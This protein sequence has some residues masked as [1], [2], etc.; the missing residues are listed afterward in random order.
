[1]T[2]RTPRALDL[3]PAL[4]EAAGRPVRTYCA[5]GFRSYLAHRVLAQAGV[6]SATLDG[7]LQTLRAMRPDVVLE[8]GA[9][10]RALV[11]AGR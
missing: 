4:V 9:G 10:V 1:M 7:G 6:D 11:G 8:P 5:S 3:S 2:A